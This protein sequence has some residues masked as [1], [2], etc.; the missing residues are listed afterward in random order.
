M[1]GHAETSKVTLTTVES[2]VAQ[3]M[4]WTIEINSITRSIAWRSTQE[5]WISRAI[6]KSMQTFINSTKDHLLTFRS[7]WKEAMSIVQHRFWLKRST[8]WMVRLSQRTTAQCSSSMQNS[9]AN[10]ASRREQLLSLAQSK[11]LLMPDV[12]QSQHDQRSRKL[13]H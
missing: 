3:S 1:E 10:R 6:W 11:S 2:L 9:L 12:C 8:R 13:L 5:S 4:L 7:N